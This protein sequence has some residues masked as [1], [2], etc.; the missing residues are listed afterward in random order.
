MTPEQKLRW[1]SGSFDLARR[2]NDMV[3]KYDPLFYLVHLN[4]YYMNPANRN[5]DLGNAI[6]DIGLPL[7]DLTFAEEQPRP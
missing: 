2:E 1:I 5:V 6:A 3:I 4:A 7:G